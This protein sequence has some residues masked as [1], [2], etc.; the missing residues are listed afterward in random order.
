M[1]DSPPLDR[2]AAK[3][4]LHKSL[5]ISISIWDHIME[6]SHAVLDEANSPVAILALGKEEIFVLIRP[7]FPTPL[8]A[9]RVEVLRR[10]LN[11]VLSEEG[12][13]SCGMWDFAHAL[14]HILWDP[15]EELPEV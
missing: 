7:H 12:L 10:V 2:A 5:D 11:G 9:R 4:Q 14:D 8:A 3:L 13:T 6:R 15:I 1:I